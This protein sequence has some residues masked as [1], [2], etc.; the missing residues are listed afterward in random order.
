DL[1]RWHIRRGERGANMALKNLEH[2]DLMIR[3]A[4]KKALENQE[5]ALWREKLLE[6]SETQSSWMLLANIPDQHP[7]LINELKKVN[8]AESPAVKQAQFLSVGHAI[9]DN[10]D[11][12]KNAHHADL[13]LIYQ[14]FPT[15][16]AIVDG[17]FAD[18]LIR[19][20]TGGILDDCLDAL[21]AATLPKYIEAVAAPCPRIQ[22]NWTTQKFQRYFASLQRA[23]ARSDDPSLREKLQTH[24]NAMKEKLSEGDQKA[25]AN[26][27]RAIQPR[28]DY[29][30][31]KQTIAPLLYKKNSAAA[32]KTELARLTDELKEILTRD[33][34]AKFLLIGFANDSPYD[35][36]N[37]DISENRAKFLRDALGRN[38]IPKAAISYEAR[39]DQGGDGDQARRVDIIVNAQ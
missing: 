16:E 22:H 28:G 37:R 9:L 24:R 34:S 2:D 38:G 6:A 21:D 5:E 14:G 15:G 4:A 30:A 32:P 20:K 7:A 35:T 31:S 27:M 12:E 3:Y 13:K 17:S 36:T 8:F 23:E 11:A 18:M 25:L 26:W 19:L 1:E 33:P 39:G 29:D 10:A